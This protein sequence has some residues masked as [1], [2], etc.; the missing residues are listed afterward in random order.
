LFFI[1]HVITDG[2]P[3]SMILAAFLLSPILISISNS[4]KYSI[5]DYFSKLLTMQSLKYCT[6]IVTI[7]ILT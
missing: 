2:G 4:K 1:G 6:L 3:L 5:S 7:F